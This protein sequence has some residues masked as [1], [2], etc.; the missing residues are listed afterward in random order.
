MAEDGQPARGDA[1]HC[2]RGEDAIELPVVGG[3]RAGR[4]DRFDG[5]VQPGLIEAFAGGCTRQ[6]SMSTLV[7][8]WESSRCATSAVPPAARTD[9]EER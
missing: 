3:Q 4:I 8:A 2:N 7:T 9:I 1:A 5:G 6:P